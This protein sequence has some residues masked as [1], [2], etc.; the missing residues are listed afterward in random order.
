MASPTLRIVRGLLSGSTVSRPASPTP[1]MAGELNS[2]PL[3]Y[4]SMPSE[5]ILPSRR[6]PICHPLGL[7]EKCGSLMCGIWILKPVKKPLMASTMP[8]IV[9]LA[10]SMGFTMAFLTLL[11]MP[12]T[13]ETNPLN[14]PTTPETSELATLET[15]LLMLFQIEDATL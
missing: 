11:K 14:V 2:P 5:G 7:M 12:V 9:L 13:V 1:M 4:Q 6:S 15:V 3:A 8:L 10:V